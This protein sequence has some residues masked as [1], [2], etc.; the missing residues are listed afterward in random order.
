[1]KR[2]TINLLIAFAIISMSLSSCFYRGDEG[3]AYRHRTEHRGHQRGGGHEGRHQGGH[4]GG[5][6]RR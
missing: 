3:H 6:E 4:E 2:N 5:G 1:M